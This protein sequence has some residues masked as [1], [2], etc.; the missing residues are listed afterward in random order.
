MITDLANRLSDGLAPSRPF[1]N[2]LTEA[3]IRGIATPVLAAAATGLIGAS[4]WV[5]R[6]EA[7][8]GRG[9]W[10][11]NPLVVLVAVL[12]VQVG[13]GFADQARLSDIPLLVVHLAATGVVLL[14]LRVGLH[15]IL[16]HEAHDVA[17]GPST[18]CSQCYHVVPLMPFCPSCGVALAATTKRHRGTGLGS[19]EAGAELDDNAPFDAVEGGVVVPGWPTLAAG[20]ASSSSWA[21]YPMA[22]APEARAHRGHHTLLLSMFGSGLTA[23][24][25]A[26]VLTAV[27]G[28][29]T[30]PAHKCVDNIC[31]RPPIRAPGVPAP[32]LASVIS[33]A[34]A[35]TP[36]PAPVAPYNSP[37]GKYSVAL[38]LSWPGKV[39]L[40]AKTSSLISFVFQNAS[41]GS[42]KLSCGIIQVGDFSG[43]GGATAQQV[44][45]T[46]IS[47]NVPSASMAYPVPDPLVGL[48]PGYGAVYNANL[49]SSSGQ[50][51]TYRILVM[52]AV[53][54]GV[55]V[56]VWAEGPDDPSFQSL[57][58]LDHPSFIDM[59]VATLGL[60][61]TINSIQW[62]GASA[63]NS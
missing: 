46:L 47:K 38:L 19:L 6:A 33:A 14:A 7:G 40:G 12:V 57:P 2:I 8:Q 54:N 27:T 23:I 58:L 48:T 43:L 22:P 56:V 26:L 63:F 55:A 9:R 31:S 16:L 49:N 21:G 4:I 13:L 34:T 61:P 32:G 50:Q 52:A 45:D 53:K 62:K 28:P 42:T 30:T 11:A 35:G 5:H 1:T 37:D 24:V 18:T 41:I 20:A 15:H 25:V 59:D 51:V 10:I 3:L 36:D 29:D 60:D 39:S 44:V 17:V